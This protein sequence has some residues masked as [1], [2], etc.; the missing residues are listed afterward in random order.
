MLGVM[1]EQRDPLQDTRLLLAQ[2]WLWEA[3]RSCLSVLERQP[4][5]INTLRLA[6]QIARR[7]A[8]GQLAVDLLIRAARIVPAMQAYLRSSRSC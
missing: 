8:K 4:T 5:D 7:A 1:S 6:A 2:G 3:E